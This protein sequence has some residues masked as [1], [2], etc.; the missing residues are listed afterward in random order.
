MSAERAWWSRRFVAALESGADPGRLRRGR[1]L[2]ARGAVADLRVRAGEVAARVQGS[3]P[4]PYRV[5][6]LLPALG[7]DQWAV[8]AAALAGQPMFR[9]RLLAGELPPEVE[10]VFDVLGLPLLPQG[11]GGLAM[12]CSCPDYG[13]P[14]K[15]AAAVLYVLAAALDDDPFLLLA[16]LGRDRGAFLSELRRRAGAAE[17]GDAADGGGFGDLP[18]P[19][20]A[21][22]PL[23]A[24]PAAFWAAPPLPDPPPGRPEPVVFTVDA[25]DAAAG[26]LDALAPVYERL[27]ER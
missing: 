22:V 17:D 2:A 25:P 4:R 19:D 20:G 5:A 26:L 27:T 9:A 11:L 8:A 6:L 16:W 3:R 21:P 18:P 12:T 15:H 24:D 7:D 1:D 10:R 14:C 23:P 13:D